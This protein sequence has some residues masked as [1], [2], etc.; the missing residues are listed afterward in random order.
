[1]RL[2][3]LA[4]VA[5][6]G[7]GLVAVPTARAQ[8]APPAAPQLPG[9]PTSDYQPAGCNSPD[10]PKGYARCFAE[11][12][13]GSAHRVVPNVSGP[14]SSALG[15]AEIQSAYHLPSGGQGQTVAIV[16]AGGDSSAE[17]DLGVFRS[18]YG[19]P[20]CTAANGCFRKVDQ[21]GGTDLP[22]DD[23][24]WAQE[25][26]L[27]LDA[28]SAACPLCH[29]LL[30]EGNTA[31]ADDLGT[32]AET[33]VALGAKF[34]SNSYGVSGEDPDEVAYNHYYDHPGVAVTASTG[35]LGNVT[36][37]PA[38]DPNVV[39]VGGTTLTRDST[40][41]RGWT[42]AAWSGGGSGCSPYEPHPAYQDGIDTQ[43][44]NGRAIADIAADA[45]P[46]TGLA[47]YDSLPYLGQ[48]GWMQVGGTSLSSPLVASMYALAGTPVAGTNPATYPYSAASSDLNDVTQGTDGSCGTVL[49][50]AGAGW[51]GPTGLGTPAGVGALTFGPA[52]TLTGHVTDEDTGKPVAGVSVAATNEDNGRTYRATTDAQGG[53]QLI[54]SAGDYDVS[55]SMFA[56]QDT[57]RTGVRVAD[58]QA[59]TADLAMRPVPSVT[60]SGTVTDGDDHGWPLSA[61]VTIDGY[62]FGAVSTDPYTG[63][64]SVTLPEQHNYTFHVSADY[65]GY[66]GRDLQ[67]D[68]GTTGTRADA[69]LAVDRTGCTA[70]GYAYPSRTDFEGW[71][72][73]TPQQGWTVSGTA[74]GWE[75]DNPANF[76]NLTGGTGNFATADP[77]NTG[78][79]EDTVLTSPAV[80]L[81]GQSAPQ[82]QFRST[83]VPADDGSTT[84]DVEVSVD[85]GATWTLAGHP[86]AGFFEKNSIA[87]PQAAHQPDVKV[88]FHYAGQGVTI[89][90]L[91]DV[92]VGGCATLPGGLVD[93][94]LSD[95]NTGDP[96]PGA[97]VSG[98]TGSGSVPA[99][100]DGFYWTFA[101]PGAQHLTASAG[102][103]ADTNGT[104]AVTADTVTRHDWKLKAGQLMA[105]TGSVSV[106]EELGAAKGTAVKLTNTGGAPLHI[107]IGEHTTG[108][109]PMAGTGGKGAPLRMVKG[110]Y[111]PGPAK[112]GAAPALRDATA[113]SGP[114]T[115]IA[116]YPT[117]IIDN[118][119]GYDQGKVYSFGGATDTAITAAGYVYDPVAGAW[120]RL[121]DLPQPLEGPSGAFLNGTMY[122]VGGWNTKSQ[123]VDALYAY[124]PGTDSWTQLANLPESVGSPSI[125]VLAGQL[126]VVGGCTGICLTGT[127]AAYRYAPASNTWTRIADYPTRQTRGACAGI[128]DE[129]VC[130]GGIDIDV[131]KSLS[132]TYA[133]HPQTD[134]WTRQAD[135][136]YDNWAMAYAGANDRLQVAGGITGLSA[137]NRA[138]QYDPV[139]DTWS[140]LPNANNVFYR[141]GSSCGLYQIGGSAG[142][143]PTGQPFA[144]VLPGYDSCGGSDVPWL[145]ESKSEIDLAAGA[146]TTVTVTAD[147]SAVPQPGSYTATLSL[148]TDSPYSY[149]PISVTLQVKPPKSWGKVSG[150]VTDAGTG[151]P[152]AG[153]TVQVCTMYRSKTGQCGPVSYTLKTDAGGHYQLWLDKGYNPLHITAAMNGYQPRFAV[154]QIRKGADTPA[155]FAL[156]KI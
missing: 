147:S 128:H 81:S 89:W 5:C 112:P 34:V 140:A 138:A 44:P 45:D 30:V 76:G 4:A 72:G 59:V 156:P 133:Y 70:P 90:Q 154:V 46:A 117:P 71:T 109:T 18:Q 119:V 88:R 136:P 152:I 75:F 111:T 16:D 125:A 14:P 23:P 37:W 27:D 95:A 137:T 113:A 63:R 149:H 28:V 80:D 142:G 122:V 12:R 42:E 21:N 26:S 1:M 114:W 49:C 110:N 124:H 78:A 115:D 134:T 99:A 121:A 135:M 51:D 32:A 144:E 36:N 116:D 35:D 103:Y 106:S 11:I 143:L 141:P 79:T 53:Y 148:D 3:V 97:T 43:C 83:Y 87:L 92:T 55:A 131:P 2:S 150:T 65:P 7:V 57:T 48:S 130:A 74:T 105:S 8:A 101:A 15:P 108:F 100:A 123:T 19:L 104:V 47:V 24:S 82:L 146:S 68:L 56:Y 129:V 54:V 93:G 33:A 102:R 118:A 22:A 13:T 96:V 64:Y 132:T 66:S 20:E 58:G 10:V 91:D 98:S 94:V 31:S 39:A 69:A 60:V 84:G 25:T 29:I 139:T 73:T 40:A 85:G 77:Y 151:A 50:T 153:A 17:A 67:V 107:S 155:N 38:S 126:Y 61:K 127:S 41:A 86:V 62:P 145:A 120:S 52:G 9:A 6:L